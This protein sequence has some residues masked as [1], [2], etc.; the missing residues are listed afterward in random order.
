[1]TD[2]RLSVESINVDGVTLSLSLPFPDLSSVNV[3]M[4]R[5]SSRCNIIIHIISNIIMLSVGSTEPN[6]PE[7][8][9]NVPSE[10]LRLLFLRPGRFRGLITGFLDSE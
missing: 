7:L 4:E 8:L 3:V 1:M 9:C 6:Q 5:S 2:Q 10:Q